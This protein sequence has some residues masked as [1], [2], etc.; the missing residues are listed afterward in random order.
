[1][2]ALE[3]V[4]LFKGLIDL[5]SYGVNWNSDELQWSSVWEHQESCQL[6]LL[7]FHLPVCNYVKLGSDA[8]VIVIPDAGL[9]LPLTETE[10]G[11]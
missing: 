3:L 9:P 7:N 2:I 11:S 1:M 4:D 10:A 5:Y 8:A 6:I